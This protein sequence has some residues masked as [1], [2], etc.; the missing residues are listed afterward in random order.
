VKLVKPGFEVMAASGHS[1][2]PFDYSRPFELIEAAGRTCYKSEDKAWTVCPDCGGTGYTEPP[3]PDCDSEDDALRVFGVCPTCDGGKWK[4][5]AEK[6]VDMLEKRGHFAMLEHSWL[7]GVAKDNGHFYVFAQYPTPFLQV[8]RNQYND[9]VEVAG[10]LRAFAEYLDLPFTKLFPVKNLLMPFNVVNPAEVPDSDDWLCAMTVRIVCDRGVT[11]E[12]VRHRPASYAQEST[13]YCNY[14]GGVTFVVPPWVEIEPGEYDALQV[15]DY[16]DAFIK[17]N[18]GNWREVLGPVKA[19][20]HAML[21]AES[22]YTSLL[23]KGQRPEQARAVLPNSL[24]TE[25][26]VTASLEE[27]RHIFKLRTAKA[28]HPQMREIMVPLQEEARA[29]FP[30]VFGAAA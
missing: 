10:N 2:L 7:A 24:K 22:A 12:I 14:G 15:N 29:L 19:W 5:S 21:H 1:D 20:L 9:D 17:A 23:K 4:S 25:I 6:F 27:W 26:V 3:P 16:S 18:P 13:R 8:G 30:G 28:A 11:H